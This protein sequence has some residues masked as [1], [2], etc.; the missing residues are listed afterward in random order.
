MCP[1]NIRR[2]DLPPLRVLFW[3]ERKYNVSM[4]I[5]FNDFKK[6]DV[7]EVCSGKRLGKVKDLSFSFPDGKIKNITAGGLF[8]GDDTVL[9]FSAITRIGEDAILVEKKKPVPPPPPKG[10][11]PQGNGCPPPLPRYD[12]EN[13]QARLDDDDYE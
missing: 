13:R 12:E 6:K 4:E 9:P 10:C 8:C 11:R 5:D 1:N 7:I 3:K 2:L